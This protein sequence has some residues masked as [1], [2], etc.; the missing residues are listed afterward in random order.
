MKKKILLVITLLLFIT[1]LT[2]AYAARTSSVQEADGGGGGASIKTKSSN[3]LNKKDITTEC[4]YSDGSLF[5][6]SYVDGNQS[7]SRETSQISTNTSSSNDNIS[8]VSILNNSTKANGTCYSNVSS[9]VLSKQIKN[10][11]DEGNE[12]GNS[13][14]VNV[15]S[16]KF[17]DSAQGFTYG[18]VGQKKPWYKIFTTNEE[19]NSQAVDSGKIKTYSLVSERIYIENEKIL[20]QASTCYYVKKSEQAAGSNSYLTFYLFNNITLIENNGMITSYYSTLGACPTL[21]IFLNDPSQKID[22]SK[23]SPKYFYKYSR[24]HYSSVSEEGYEDKYEPTNEPPSNDG[25]TGKNACESIPQTVKV[26]KTIIQV[27][28][29]GIPAFVII[30]TSIDIFRMVVADNLTEELPKRKKIII[31]R[32][33]IMIVFFFLPLIINVLLN[34]LYNSSSWFK[35][36]VGINNINCLFK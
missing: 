32:F 22:T 5:I 36:E 10:T 34:I 31:I 23:S 3:D 8:E 1:P 27:M 18:E 16:Y 26:L 17:G 33:I 24:F 35:K 28:Q 9:V 20:T 12:V 11:D 6:T 2:D 7:V 29:L 19:Y 14:V 30:L 25:Q 21:S 13:Y 4:I 15:A